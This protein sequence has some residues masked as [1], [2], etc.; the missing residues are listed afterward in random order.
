MSQTVD[1]L[2]PG[3]RTEFDVAI[4]V[5][6]LVTKG[7]GEDG[8]ARSLFAGTRTAHLFGKKGLLSVLFLSVQSLLVPFPLPF[9]SFVSS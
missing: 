8:T 6:L 9:H 7:S 3:F 1:S 2:G 4:P 5:R